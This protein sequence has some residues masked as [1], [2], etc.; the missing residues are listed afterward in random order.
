MIKV[1]HAT[2]IVLSGLI[3]LIVG[4]LLLKLGLGL[5]VGVI[6]PDYMVLPS[7]YPVITLLTPYLGSKENGVLL[8]IA[9]SLYLGYIKGRYVLGKSAHRGVARIRAFPNPTLLSNIYSAKYYILLGAMVALGMSIKFLGIPND[10][11]GFVDVAIGSALINGAIIY[12]RSARRS[13]SS[14]T[15]Q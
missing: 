14:V 10:V 2:M 13:P 8:L 15:P 11:R 5:L 7:H 9:G 4:A 1:S 6:Q 12:F 3:W